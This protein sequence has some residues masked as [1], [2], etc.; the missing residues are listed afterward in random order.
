[1]TKKLAIL[2]ASAAIVGAL[3]A[4]ASAAGPVKATPAKTEL[5]GQDHY[6]YYDYT[7]RPLACKV[8]LHPFCHR[9]PGACAWTPTC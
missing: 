7:R 8:V 6:Y 9:Y 4:P 2:A 3:A 1:M 5:V